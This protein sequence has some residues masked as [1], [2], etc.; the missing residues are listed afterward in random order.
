MCRV[1]WLGVKRLDFIASN[2]DTATKDKRESLCNLFGP[3]SLSVPPFP[4]ICHG[5]LPVG[6]D[7]ASC[8]HCSNISGFNNYVMTINT[9]KVYSILIVPHVS[10]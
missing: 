3:E 8:K 2:S 10:T 9:T 1:T 7:L 5:L 4:E 6:K